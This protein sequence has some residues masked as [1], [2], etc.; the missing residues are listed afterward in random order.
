MSKNL[1]TNLVG[2]P[3]GVEYRELR[4][5]VQPSS[6]VD[7]LVVKHHYSHKATKNRMLSMVVF[8]TD[9][10]N[11]PLGFI[12]LG[13]GI[14]P[15]MKHTI[16]TDITKDNYCE[17]DR[18]WLDDVL[19]R[20]SETMVIGM[21]LWFIKRWNPKIEYIITYADGS[22][23]NVGTIYKASNAISI[24]KIPVDFYV[25]ANGERVHPVTMWH[26][27]GTRAGTALQELYP[28]IT[29]IK[30]TAYQ[31]RFLY[32]LNDKKRK[33]WNSN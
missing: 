1:I 19:P 28:G 11:N 2:E 21:L 5:V 23:G 22:V 6:L 17:F 9:H 12:Q 31:Y 33:R 24:G 13:Y 18:M 16:S 20:N 26:R 10:G 7:E 8:H 29:H 30:G 4:L 32:I 3:I 25:L 27:H 14:R 15:Q